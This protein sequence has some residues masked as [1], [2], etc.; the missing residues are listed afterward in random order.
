MK[1][2][3]AREVTRETPQL[4]PMNLQLFADDGG[5]DGNG[6]DDGGDGAGDEKGD[7]PPSFDELLASGHQSEFDR[8]VQKATKTALENERK[9]AK[10]LLDDTLSEAEKLANMNVQQKAEYERDKALKELAEFQR[11]DTLI[12]MTKTAR[13]MLVDENISISEGL[14]ESLV[15]ED[16]ETT[17]T[18]VADFAKS[19]TDA[20]DKAVKE[21]LKGEPPKGGKGQS[22]ITKEDIDKIQ[23]KGER[24]K[25]IQENQHLYD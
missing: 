22:K 5:D 3:I 15:A 10:A 6:G 14:I 24:L 19:F 2:L 4:L 17:K 11:K 23:D 20:V 18:N 16:A 9:K 13:A 25:A 21:A 1:N 7:V 8:R 12:S